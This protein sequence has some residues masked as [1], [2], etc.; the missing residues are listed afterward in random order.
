VWAVGVGSGSING[1]VD[2]SNYDL[3]LKALGFDSRQGF[4]LVD[5]MILVDTG[6]R[7]GL[8]LYPTC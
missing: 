7:K 4:F 1:S 6:S 5:N 3:K 2:G 8:C